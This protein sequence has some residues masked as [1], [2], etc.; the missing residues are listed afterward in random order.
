MIIHHVY[1]RTGAH[2][3]LRYFQLT[4]V[5]GPVERCCTVGLWCI[6]IDL[7][8]QHRSHRLEVSGP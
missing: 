2:Q 6:H 7:T 4:P 3:Q 1:A 8:C 5:N